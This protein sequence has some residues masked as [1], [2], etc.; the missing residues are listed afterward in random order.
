MTKISKTGTMDYNEL[1]KLDVYEFFLL[2]T[3]IEKQ[4]KTT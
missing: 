3:N 2:L 4:N 1:K